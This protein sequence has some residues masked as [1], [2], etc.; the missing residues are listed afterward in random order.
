MYETLAVRE[1]QPGVIEIAFARQAAAN[2]LSTRMGEE[3]LALWTR[4]GSDES[5]RAAVLTGQGR[6]FCAGADLKERD[7]MTDAA[8]ATQHVLF[9]AMI[10]AQLA[11]PFPL[12]AAVN[13]AA[14]GGGFEMALAC[15]FIWAAE[16]A[17]FGLP[18]VKLGIMPGLGGTQILA[19]TVGPAKA[20]ELL[21]TGK[22]LT[23]AE[24]Q[25]FGFVTRVLPGEE[26]VE[27]ALEE[28]GRI[29][30]NAPLS[31][32]ALK[33]VVRAGAGLALPEAMEVE[34]ESY[35]RLFV[36]EDRHEGIAAFNEKRSPSFRG[37]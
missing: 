11:L 18:E 20:I 33:H 3:L 10:R 1:A 4:L 12:I 14:M 17:R 13:G 5:V 16:A 34:L 7:G 6:I 31:V 36:T 9:E 30:A 32:R 28:A 21:T 26:L 27:A 8:W 35:N 2:S 19:R 25:G 23:A 37:R 24:A 29:A 22:A 15:D